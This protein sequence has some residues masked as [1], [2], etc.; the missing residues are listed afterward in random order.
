MNSCCRSNVTAKPGENLTKF[1]VNHTTEKLYIF[2]D[3]LV[4]S[5]V[6]NFYVKKFKVKFMSE[7]SKLPSLEQVLLILGQ[8][9]VVTIRVMDEYTGKEK[10]LFHEQLYKAGDQL[11]HLLPL[12]VKILAPHTDYHVNILLMKRFSRS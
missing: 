11:D 3:F 5:K 12:K 10:I 6:N 2:Q 7:K 8:H 4:K 1:E 9:M